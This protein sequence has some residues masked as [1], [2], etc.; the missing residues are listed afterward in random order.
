MENSLVDELTSESEIRDAYPVMKQLRPISEEEYLRLVETMRSEEGYR[1]FAMRDEKDGEIRGLAG[2]A[3]GTT[4]YHGK[5]VWVHDLVI[6]EPYRSKGVGSRLLDWIEDWA[7]ARDCTRFELASGLWRD[8]AHE[9]YENNG[10][11]RY[12]YTFKKDLSVE[13]PY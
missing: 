7:A 12:C 11:D 6:D 10:M 2:L 5:H 1:L 4:L 3:I 13:P 9:F 8:R